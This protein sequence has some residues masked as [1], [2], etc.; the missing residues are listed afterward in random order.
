MNCPVSMSRARVSSVARA[1][2]PYRPPRDGALGQ[3]V[4]TFL[5]TYY[6][7]RPFTAPAPR[8][9]PGASPRPG[10]S[11][12]AHADDETCNA[13]YYNREMV[14]ERARAATALD[15]IHGRGARRA[16]DVATAPRA[17]VH[18]ADPTAASGSAREAMAEA[19]SLPCFPL[20]AA[21]RPC[22]SRRSRATSRSS[23][24]SCCDARI[25]A[26]PLCGR[27]GSALRRW[28]P[29]RAVVASSGS[30]AD[31]PRVERVAP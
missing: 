16:R 20:E 13:T 17:D 21:S 25:R 10:G 15:S 6:V 9:W 2:Q 26:A 4:S 3:E 8:R 5:H 1:W 28:A 12:C 29:Y 31:T 14:V 11:V 27:N 19:A 22:L 18:D 7:S 23:C 24:P 30:T